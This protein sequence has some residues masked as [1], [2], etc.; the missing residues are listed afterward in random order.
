M[1]EYGLIGYPL[2]HSFSKKYFSEKFEKE[3]ISEKDLNRI[4]AGLETEMSL[5]KNM[6]VNVIR[7]YTGVPK[8]WIQYI[9]EQYGI[10]TILNHSIIDAWQLLNELI[11]LLIFTIIF[12][13][14][15]LF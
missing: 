15:H 9:Y 12:K 8:R 6:G 7:Q 11:L 13:S 10:Y 1:K 4:K 14:G 5:L 2:S 3:G